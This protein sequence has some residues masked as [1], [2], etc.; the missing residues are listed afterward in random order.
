MQDNRA[1]A[2]NG[3]FAESLMLRVYLAQVLSADQLL[4]QS[5][6]FYALASEVV[7]NFDT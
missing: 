1:F 7:Q 3:T 4:T 5:R 6:S 2:S